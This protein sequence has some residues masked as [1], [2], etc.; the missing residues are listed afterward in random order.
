MFAASPLRRHWWEA[1]KRWRKA[2]P[3]LCHEGW[4]FT[5]IKHCMY[6]QTLLVLLNCL[7]P[8]HYF[9]L[10]NRDGFL[11]R[12]GRR[13][14]PRNNGDMKT[15]DISNIFSKDV[16][17]GV[18]VWRK[19]GLDLEPKHTQI[20]IPYTP[21][22]TCVTLGWLLKL[23]GPHLSNKLNEGLGLMTIL[24]SHPA[25]NLGSFDTSTESP[26]PAFPDGICANWP[27]R[28]PKEVPC[29]WLFVLSG[30]AA[31]KLERRKKCTGLYKQAR[32]W[33]K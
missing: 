1:K 12:G 5:A 27:P 33:E 15:K 30:E 31:L 16:S 8:L 24:T 32:G 2:T 25:L 6:Y 17:R 14:I 7:F 22:T 28:L 21:L 9:F 29:S 19:G 20:W 23:P 13:D 18:I 3:S 10:W 4:G 26:P 11:S